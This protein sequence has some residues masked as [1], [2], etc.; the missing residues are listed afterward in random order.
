MDAKAM[1]ILKRALE[2]NAS[3]VYIVAGCPLAYKINGEIV[4]ESE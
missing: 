4:N 1:D 3:D 2:K